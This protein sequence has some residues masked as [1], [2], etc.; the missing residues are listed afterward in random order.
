M[1]QDA[2]NLYWDLIC[3][4]GGGSAEVKGQLHGMGCLISPKHVITA[5]HVISGVQSR[6]EWPVVLKYDGLYKCEPL[7]YSEEYDNAILEVRDKLEH[8]DSPEPKEYPAVY[9]NKPLLGLSVGYV[10]ALHIHKR[11]GELIRRTYFSHAYVSMLAPRESK[12]GERYALS[13]GIIQEGFSGGPVFTKDKELVGLI[14][15]SVQFSVD[16]EQPATSRQT[17]P[18][19]TPLYRLKGSIEEFLATHK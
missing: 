15:E 19:I 7:L 5:Y 16:M 8:G 18:V 1:Y 4:V 12:T 13:N 6:Y 10:A 2:C 17:L 14:V 3:Q 9:P 11:N